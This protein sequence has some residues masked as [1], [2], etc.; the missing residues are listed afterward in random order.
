MNDILFLIISSIIF[1]QMIIYFNTNVRYKMNYLQNTEKFEQMF[2]KE[3]FII[4]KFY[5]N[6]NKS[7]IL[8][9]NYTTASIYSKHEIKKKYTKISVK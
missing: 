6:A 5:T 9:R 2:K 4:N 7:I 3:M 1:T 8:S